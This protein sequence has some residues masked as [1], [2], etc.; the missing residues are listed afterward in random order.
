MTI[1]DNP[2][3]KI[4]QVGR[5]IAETGGGRVI[6]ETSMNMSKSGYE[7]R[8]LSDVDH[9]VPDI[10]ET[11]YSIEITP[12]GRILEEWQPGNI[13]CKVIRKFLRLVVF[14]FFGTI[15]ARFYARKGWIVLNHNIEIFSGDILVLHNVFNAEHLQDK[16]PFFIK[17]LRWLNPVFSFRIVRERLMLGRKNN[18]AI[19]A[20]SYRTMQEAKPYIANDP[21]LVT[22]NN[23]VNPVKFFPTGCADRNN[24]RLSDGLYGQFVL[25]FVGHEFERKGLDILISALSLLPEKVHLRIIGGRLSNQLKFEKLS[26]ESGVRQ[27]VDFLGTCLNTLEHYRMADVFVLPSA[28]EAWALVGLEAMACGT[29]V[30]MTSAGGVSEYLEDGRNGFVIERTP[31]D[32]A[33][34]VRILM[35]DPDLMQRM[36]KN[37]RE[38]ALRYSWESVAERYLGLIRRVAEEKASHA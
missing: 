36:R 4:L 28:Y 1:D 9:T 35:D 15:R 13:G 34:K 14:S 3:L 27:R 32:I 10:S 26:I 12:F 22:I 25:L 23:G 5:D 6:I 7:V 8:I 18:F 38:T 16:R 19:S 29:P 31:E 17:S 30:L 20:V 21:L 2:T 33:E 11:P 24:R 37:A